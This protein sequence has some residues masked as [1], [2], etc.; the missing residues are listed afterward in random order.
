MSANICTSSDYLRD[1][2]TS[3]LVRDFTS[4]QTTSFMKQQNKE[5]CKPNLIQ[6]GMIEADRFSVLLVPTKKHILPKQPLSHTKEKTP[7]C[8]VYGAK[9]A[10]NDFARDQS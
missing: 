9:N 7:H 8:V 4:V 3:P 1:A 5:P 2:C 6:P 10:P